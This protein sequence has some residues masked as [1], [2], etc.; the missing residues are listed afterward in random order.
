[1]HSFNIKKFFLVCIYLSQK[2]RQIKSCFCIRFL[3][4]SQYCFQQFNR[5]PTN[6]NTRIIDYP[7]EAVRRYSAKSLFLT[8]SQ[9]S[10]D[11]TC[12]GVP[13]KYRYKPSVCNF[14][15]NK[16]RHMCFPVSFEKILRTLF[17]IGPVRATASYHLLNIS[18]KFRVL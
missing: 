13:F 17:L 16:L 5:F 12:A 15:K 1:M 4:L 7:K 11:T 3:E 10:K 2:A 14:I 18:P 8:I 6:R 9:Y